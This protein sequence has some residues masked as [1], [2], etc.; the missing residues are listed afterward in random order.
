L[1]S[2]I[3]GDT[4][5]IDLK[6]RKITTKIEDIPKIAK[7]IAKHKCVKAIYLFGS[8]A[9]GKTHT[10]SDIDICVITNGVEFGGLGGSDNLDI[11]YFHRLPLIIQFRVFRDGK[12]LVIKD[13]DF[14]D[15]IKIVTL[16]KYLDYK[17]IIDRYVWENF[18]CMT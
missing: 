6:D 1:A 10:L 7:E 4:M 11:V 12:L 3:W 16:N 15:K 17:H 13:K 18:R 5:R 2:W 9:T 8:Q 14:V